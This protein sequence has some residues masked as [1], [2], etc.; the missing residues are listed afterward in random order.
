MI[1][2][3]RSKNFIR[4]IQEINDLLN[5]SQIFNMRALSYAR[6]QTSLLLKF[7]MPFLYGTSV[8]WLFL[9]SL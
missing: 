7:R 5:F 2:N 1:L 6:K 4:K 3:L 9:N 8:W